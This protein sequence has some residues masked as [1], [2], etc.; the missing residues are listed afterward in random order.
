MTTLESKAVRRGWGGWFGI[1]ALAVVVAATLATAAQPSALT[2]STIH[3]AL[4]EYVL[5]LWLMMDMSSDDWRAATSRGRFAR[6]LWT[7]ACLTFLV[8]VACAFHFTHHW[9]HAHAFE[10][11]RLESGWGEG[12]YVNYL[13]MAVWT[14]DVLWWWQSPATYA[15]RNRW[16]DRLLQGFLLFIAFNAT[17]AFAHGA[18]QY[19]GIAAS[20][21]LAMRWF[22]KPNRH[23]SGDS[24]AD[25]SSEPSV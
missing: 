19:A 4:V 12:L 16:I 9:S 13:V 10:R 23:R 6:W 8:H 21:L 25:Q 17:V 14:A 15:F 18:I 24:T 3:L 1:I 22:L 2:R 7:W 11:T 20:L 5:A